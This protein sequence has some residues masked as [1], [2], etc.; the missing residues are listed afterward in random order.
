MKQI[1]KRLAVALTPVYVWFA[2]FAVFEPNN[3]FGLKAGADSSQPVARVRAYQKQ[4]GSRLVLGDS[5]LAHFDEAYLAE[6]CGEEWQN[7][8]FGGASLRETLDLAQYILDS[9][10]PVERMVLGISFYV[11]NAGYDTDRFAAL[12]ETLQNP[13]AYCLNLEY[14]VN[15][16]TRFQNW[17]LHTP[18]TVESGDWGPEDYFDADGA[19]IPVHRILYDYSGLIAPRCKNWA[20]NDA[21]FARIPQLAE[22]CRT[23]GI[24]LTVVLPPMAGIVRETVCV[25]FGIEAQMENAVLPQLRAWAQEYGFALLDYEWGGSCITDDDTQFYDGFHL[26]EVYGLPQWTRQLFA[27][28][29]RPRELSASA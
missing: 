7:L 8:A 5:R 13:L 16:L 29:Y 28:V 20:L 4:P 10:H 19:P 11:L 3:Y 14:N 21:Q 6:L 26:D 18:D 2:F 1:L 12:E 15:A 24:R 22:Q 25:P 9:G 17:L 23:R 27:E